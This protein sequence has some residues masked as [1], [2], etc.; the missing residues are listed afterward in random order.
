MMHPVGEKTGK[1][2]LLVSPDDWIRAAIA[3]GSWDRF[4]ITESDCGNALKAVRE[5]S[6]SVV[7]IGAAADLGDAVLLARDLRGVGR[8]GP[9]LVMVGL[10]S[11]SEP[12]KR[13]ATL[14]SRA[15]AY[16]LENADYGE[17]VNAIERPRIREDQLP[18]PWKPAVVM[19]LILIVDVAPALGAGGRPGAARLCSM[20]GALLGLVSELRSPRNER[21]RTLVAGFAIVLA[22]SIAFAIRAYVT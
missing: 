1:R 4:Q 10:V 5:T 6:P 19:A 8:E 22:L 13:H 12:L 7:V 20:L 2:I 9:V 14:R 11:Q 18:R 16:V 17:L 3:S 21:R 15:D